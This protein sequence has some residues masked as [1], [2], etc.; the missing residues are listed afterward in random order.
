M[1]VLTTVLDRVDNTQQNTGFA[2]Y[3]IVIKA[4]ILI[5]TF[6][7]MNRIYIYVSRSK[8]SPTATT[9]RKVCSNFI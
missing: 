2:S 8:A 9:I 4:N 7:D 6:F 3:Y 1:C 5:F